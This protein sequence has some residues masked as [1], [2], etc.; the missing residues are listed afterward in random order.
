MDEKIVI[1]RGWNHKLLTIPIVLFTTIF[2]V[3]ATFSEVD[4]LVRGVGKVV[5][6]S[7]KKILQHLEGGIVEK[8]YVKEG[9]RVK[10]GDPIYKLKNTTFKSDSKEK[11]ITL[12]SLK[13]KEARLKALIESKESFELNST[14]P[15]AKNEMEIYKSELSSFNE[16]KSILEDELKQNRLEKNR[17]IEKL[18]N[19]RAEYK[20]QQEN[21]SILK[22]LISEGAASKK[23]YLSELAKS[24]SLK[25]QI[26]EIKNLIPQ[27]EQKIKSSVRKIDKFKSQKRSEWLKELNDV[28]LK[29]EQITQKKMASK[30]RE[31]RKIITSPVNGIVQKLYFHTIGGIVK[32]GDRVAEITPVDDTLIIEAKIKTNDRGNIVVDQNVTIEITAYSYTKYGLLNGKLV[33]ISPDSFVDRNGES[34][35][36]ANIEVKEFQFAPNKPILPGMSANINI[37]TGKKTIMAYLLKPLKDIRQNALR[38]K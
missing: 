33:S 1:E 3:W 8:I 30:D 19:L 36:K 4:E 10:K 25:T 15:Q 27:I 31:I 23:Q 24:Q 28:T 37:K 22:K 17:K 20:T 21:I 18:K 9:E 5:P 7:Q 12:K 26:D 13:L 35:Y 11:E 32:P 29:I 38:E 6:S 2:I 14:Q 34:Y 16:Q